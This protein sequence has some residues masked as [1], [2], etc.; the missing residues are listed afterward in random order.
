MISY[1]VEKRNQLNDLIA[2]LLR[3]DVKRIDTDA[4]YAEEFLRKLGENGFLTSKRKLPKEVLADEVYV[5]KEV[6]KVCMTTA[7]CLWCHLAC[8]TY[9]RNTKNLTLQKSVLPSLENGQLLGGTGLSNP[10]KF[11]SDM[12]SLHLHAERTEG[13][14]IVNGVLPYISNL[15]SNHGFC[16]VACTKKAQKFCNSDLVMMYLNCDTKGLTLRERANYI[17]LNG[18]ATYACKFVDVFISDKSVIATEANTFIE[19]IRP[20]FI[21]YQIPLSFG[22]MESSIHSIVRVDKKQNGCNKFLKVQPEALRLAQE[23][24]E[25]TLE[26]IISLENLPFEEVAKVRLSSA[27]ALLETV[28]TAM[29]HHGGAA[30]IKGSTPDRKLREAYFYANLTPTIKHLEKA[31]SS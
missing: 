28:Q 18:S 8:L 14:Y 13:G 20:T 12:E 11:I 27:Y 6:A 15:G 21:T 25:E 24:L 9:I 1:K 30:Y 4:F 29:I 23:E 26:K 5:V 22:V 17:G 19:E 16:F 2:R 10:M 3:P 7:F 31:L